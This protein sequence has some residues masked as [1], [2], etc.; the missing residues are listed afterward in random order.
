MN[1]VVNGTSDQGREDVFRF[2][3]KKGQRVVVECFARLVRIGL[4]SIERQRCAR[5]DIVVV[6][7]RAVA[8]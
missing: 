7:D 1:S 3:A 2:A 5:A 8:E 6:S 4:N